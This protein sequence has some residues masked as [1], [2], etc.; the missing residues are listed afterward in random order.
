[1]CTIVGT[2]SQSR[3]NSSIPGVCLVHV[4]DFADLLR[5]LWLDFMFVRI[6][7]WGRAVVDVI[8]SM[9][10]IETCYLAVCQDQMGKMMIGLQYDVP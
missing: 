1:M 6:T 5:K 3:S 10:E 7:K 9:R 8:L 2:S 4:R